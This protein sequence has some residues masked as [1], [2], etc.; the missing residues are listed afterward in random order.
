[1]R[2]RHAPHAYLKNEQIRLM[3]MI[4]AAFCRPVPPELEGQEL[5]D[6]TAASA[7]YHTGINYI[8][9]TLEF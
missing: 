6:Q 1:M 9:E 2:R 8:A 4:F 3:M 7:I 5:D